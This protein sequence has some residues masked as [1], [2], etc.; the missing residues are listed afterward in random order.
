MQKKTD[1]KKQENVCN[2]WV[3]RRFSTNSEDYFI[4]TRRYKMR[5]ERNSRKIMLHTPVFCG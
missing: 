1:K 2:D 5:L 3:N 4:A